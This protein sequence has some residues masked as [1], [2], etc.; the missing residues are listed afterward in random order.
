M[1]SIVNFYFLHWITLE[2]VVTVISGFLCYC[3]KG[4]KSGIS[5][6]AYPMEKNLKSGVP[7]AS[8][9]GFLFFVIFLIILSNSAN[10]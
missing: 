10:S 1:L 9:L 5:K 8:I 3:P 6:K 7:Q 4:T 2:I